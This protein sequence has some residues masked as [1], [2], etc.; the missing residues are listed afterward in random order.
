MNYHQVIVVGGLVDPNKPYKIG[1]VVAEVHHVKKV[2]IFWFMEKVEIRVLVLKH[3]GYI[4]I[5]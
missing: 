3:F 2:K 1:K 4:S 5:S